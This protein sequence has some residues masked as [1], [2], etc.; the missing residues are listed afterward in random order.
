MI[1]Y[2]PVFEGSLTQFHRSN[3]EVNQLRKSFDQNIYGGLMFS[4]PNNKKS[5]L[6]NNI[7]ECYF[8]IPI[9]EM[10]NKEDYAVL[11]V[12]V[13]QSCYQI[14]EKLEAYLESSFKL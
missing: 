7:P 3:H 11:T 10:C 1:G 12:T 8:F 5:L 2:Q 13:N 9:I 4:S 14:G 6:W